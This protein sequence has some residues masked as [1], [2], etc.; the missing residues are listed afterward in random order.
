MK[1]LAAALA[2]V[3]FGAAAQDAV[4][5]PVDVPAPPAEPSPTAR[6]EPTA[7][8][9]TIDAN[10]HAG[11]GKDVAALLATAPGVATQSS[12]G[13]LQRQTV[14]LR[15]ASSNGVLVLLDGIP[16]GAT[17]ASTDLSLI[18]APLV[19]RVE[20]LR[21]ASGRLGPGA[22]G[23]AVNLVTRRPTDAVELSAEG[24]GGSFGTFQGHLT[25]AGPLGPGEGLALVYGARTAGDFGYLADDTPSLPGDP[26]QRRTRANNDAAQGGGL[27]AW[28]ARSGPT[29]LDVVGE[30]MGLDRGLAGPAALPSADARQSTAHG[31]GGLRLARD[32]DGGGDLSLFSWARLDRLALRGGGLTAVA[33]AQVD[34]AAGVELSARRLVFERH[35]LE[36]TL[37]LAGEWLSGGS[38][39]PSWARLGLSV[40]DEV[41]FFDGAF[42]LVPSVR[43]DVTGPFLG[44]SPR[45]GAVALLPKGFELRA[46]VGQ[47]HRPPSFLELYVEQGTLAPNALLRPERAF[48]TD[49]A[50]AW[51]GERAFGQAA[52]FGQWTQDLITYEYY[53]PSR[54]R[55]YNFENAR[56][57]GVEL[58]ARAEPTSFVSLAA[59]YTFLLAQNLK[60]DPRYY[61]KHLPYRPQHA[62]HALASVGPSWLRARAEL[63]VQSEQYANR[64]EAVVLPARAL[65]TVGLGSKLPLAW[66]VTVSA[67]V[68]NLLDVQTMDL[69]GYPLPGRGFFLSLGVA[70]SPLKK[71][72][73]LAIAS[74]TEA[75]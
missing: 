50:V 62:A 54:A 31:L 17:G 57:L 35:G 22:L 23:G 1:H 38:A 26:L 21:G 36:G 2:L 52:V 45:L 11:E 43:L 24:A 19:D 39:A 14:S 65:V 18:P 48:A 61:L 29:S 63:L 58:E 68:R 71:T 66:P 60:E 64:T 75:P 28:R 15:G 51:R 56:A 59:S 44:V 30:G 37:S 70:L 74:T 47:A 12:A 69:D 33:A 4:L 9:T 67:E 73:P 55:P 7:V 40:S 25:G 16:L 32:L 3:S 20:V 41:L 49:A 42:S 53:P 5:P 10:E 46:N 27:L 72:V 6:R 8:T 34:A 13:L